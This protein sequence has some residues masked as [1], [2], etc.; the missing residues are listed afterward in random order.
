MSVPLWAW[1]A[2]VVVI[3]TMLAID[4]L[5][6]RT[7]HVIEFKEAARWSALWVGL[8]LSFAVVL[9]LTLGAGA[10]VDFTTAWLLEK[11]LSV[12]NLFVFALIFGYFKVPREYQHRVLFFGV[13][14]ALLFRGIFGRTRCGHR[15]P[16]HGHPVRLRSRSPL[17]RVQA[18]EGRRR[19]L[20]PRVEPRCSAAAQGDPGARRLRRY[21]VLRHGGR[22]TGGHTLARRGRR[23]R[24]GRPGLR[25]RQ[26]PCRPRGQQRPVH[27][28][29]EQRLRD[30]GPALALLPALRAARPIPPPAQGPCD[31][32][33]LHRPEACPAGHPQGHH[34]VGARDPLAGQPRRDPQRSRSVCGPEPEAAADRLRGRGQPTV[35]EHA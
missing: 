9:G 3:V 31:H 8:S 1:A 11:S 10:G 2:L 30:P 14:G 5:A 15:Q 22:P 13:I 28:L 29:L 35:L 23:D 24:G 7:A 20:R 4:L 12:D 21:V 34:R 17:Q 19:E 25:G 32:L 27:R 6:H 26:R 33:G 16:V 18:H